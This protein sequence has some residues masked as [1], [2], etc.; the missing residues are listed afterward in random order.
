MP[1][2]KS[3][4][5]RGYAWLV[6][7]RALP[8]LGVALLLCLGGGVVHAQSAAV[9]ATGPGMP[10]ILVSGIPADAPIVQTIVDQSY[11]QAKAQVGSRTR[12]DDAAWNTLLSAID[13]RLQR[14]GFSQ[15]HAFLATR[16]SVPELVAQVVPPTKHVPSVS[17]RKSAQYADGR[18]SV[19]GFVIKG[20][21]THPAADI[22]PASIQQMAQ[23]KLVQMGGSSSH[24][25]RLDF[26]QLQSVADAITRRYRKAGYLVATAYLPTQTMG[27][28]GL[29]RIDVLE[30]HIGKVVVKGADNYKPW[31]VAA[32]ANKLRGRVFRKSEVD[33][34][35]RYSHDL[36]GAVVS[37]TLKPGAK[38]GQTDLVLL[39]KESNP[40]EVTV[41]ASNYGSPTTG[42]YRADASLDWYSPLGLGDHLKASL[43]YALDPHQNTFGSLEY[44]LP[45]VPLPGLGV[46]VGI[47]RSELELNSGVFAALNVQGPTSRQFGEVHWKYLPNDNLSLLTSLRYIRE[48]STLKAMGFPLSDQKFDVAQLGL[49][50]KHTGS[51]SRSLDSISLKVRKSIKDQSRKP[52]L[53]SP[54]HADDFLVARLDY[55]HIQWISPTQQLWLKA[56]AQ[57]TRDALVP[58]EQFA[59]GGPYS[60]R[61]F[62]IAAGLSDKGFY[63]A[64]E[65]HVAA[66]GFAKVASPFGK[67]WGDVLTVE[68]F[69][70]FARGYAAGANRVVGSQ[71]STW[72]GLGVGLTFRL[73]DWNNLL[74]HLD[75]AKPLGN[76]NGLDWDDYRVYGRFNLTF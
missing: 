5:S 69:V 1:L 76:T 68:G 70:D 53:I 56:S 12:L 58:M 71:P 4:A 8:M 61:A 17:R 38:T 16:P 55:A 26:K 24:P 18:V 47:N 19:A 13:R 20:V 73:P 44:D 39:V 63:A 45:I 2:V 60:V 6:S 37:A 25:A 23:D 33:K 62:P 34:A 50:L 42:R 72:K 10:Q 15:A 28:D 49:S 74:F 9:A 32:A 11:K 67:P 48:Q 66:P 46:K 35:L 30:G 27:A 41:G 65:Y 43:S 52:D 21:G 36:P 54:N 22:S 57:Y 51:D 3:C 29:I 7:A 75:V 59:I 40:L 31:V 14:A 64:M